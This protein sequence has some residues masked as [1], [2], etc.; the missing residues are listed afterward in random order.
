MSQLKVS[1][2]I[3]PNTAVGILSP[4]TK[5][6]KTKATRVPRKF[7]SLYF[8]HLATLKSNNSKVDNLHKDISKTE[9]EVAEKSSWDQENR[10]QKL[11]LVWR[12]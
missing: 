5:R 6:T 1:A 3:I 2:D 7:R 8:A 9:T 4:K 12:N 10:G 11:G